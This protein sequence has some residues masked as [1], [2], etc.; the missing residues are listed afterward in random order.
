MFKFIIA[1][2]IISSFSCKPKKKTTGQQNLSTLT[3]LSVAK[4]NWCVYLDFKNL[5]DLGF[6]WGIPTTDTNSCSPEAAE[7]GITSGQTLRFVFNP[8]SPTAPRVVS[9]KEYL[10]YILSDDIEIGGV[11][12]SYTLHLCNHNFE[13]V[14]DLSITKTGASL[15]LKEAQQLVRNAPASASTT[16]VIAQAPTTQVFPN[17]NKRVTV[18]DFGGSERKL[19]YSCANEKEVLDLAVLY[20]GLTE[21][22]YKQYAHASSTQ[23]PIFHALIKFDKTITSLSRSVQDSSSPES[24][25]RTCIKEMQAL[26]EHAKNLETILRETQGLDTSYLSATRSIFL[27]SSRILSRNSIQ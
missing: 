10:G 8:Q 19:A 9:D 16:P 24:L 7:Q 18:A 3:A 11:T 21:L 26:A 14:C 1:S 20:K 6:V 27:L 15:T 23:E 25:T 4:D 13:S 2:L 5:K 12:T 22:E 17:K